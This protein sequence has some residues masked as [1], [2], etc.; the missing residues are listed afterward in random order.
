MD[1]IPSHV[2]AELEMRRRLDGEAAAR[3]QRLMKQLDEMTLEMEYW[4]GRH[5]SLKRFH[6]SEMARFE[7]G[8]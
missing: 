3:C 1:N 2:Y 5:E 8:R 7:G 6:E 4:K